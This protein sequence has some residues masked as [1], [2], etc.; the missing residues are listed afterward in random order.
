MRENK[1]QKVTVI[2]D[3]FRAFA[4][5]CYVLERRPKQYIY[6]SKSSV[7][8]KLASNFSNPLFIGKNEIGADIEYDIPNSPTRVTEVEV[9]NRVIMHRTEAGAKGVLRASSADIIL[10]SSFVNIH[11]TAQYIRKL[12]NPQIKITPMGHEAI[13]PSIED[14]ICAEY[15]RSLIN[16]EVFAI[17]PFI[18]E[19]KKGPGKYFFLEDQWQ[20]PEEDF[21]RCLEVNR[22]NFAIQAELCGNYALLTRCE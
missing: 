14:D 17:K 4:T 13:A 21:E 7:L 6:A 2:I 16:N 18:P 19:L 15:I 5:A 10:A 8:E 20:Y 12:H 11:A 9:T 22:F 3:A 1:N